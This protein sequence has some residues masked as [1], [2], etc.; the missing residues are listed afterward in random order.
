MCWEI[1]LRHTNLYFSA[2]TSILPSVIPLLLVCKILCSLSYIIC[3]EFRFVRN[4]M[5]LNEYSVVKSAVLPCW[6]LFRFVTFYSLRLFKWRKKPRLWRKRSLLIFQTAY[7]R[8][9]RPRARPG[10]SCRLP[11]Q[12]DGPRKLTSQKAL[13]WRRGR[14]FCLKRELSRILLEGAGRPEK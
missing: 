12:T 7:V 10:L 3:T 6:F 4:C 14:G 1:L 11:G 8:K 2:V 9:V 13:A 5:F